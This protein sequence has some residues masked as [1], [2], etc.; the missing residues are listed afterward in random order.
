MSSSPWLVSRRAIKNPD[1]D[2]LDL[3][4]AGAHTETQSMTDLAAIRYTTANGVPVSN[5]DAHH[6]H[7]V[8]LKKTGPAGVFHIR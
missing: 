1:I 6:A 4:I 7:C 2:C 8:T 3:S 5:N